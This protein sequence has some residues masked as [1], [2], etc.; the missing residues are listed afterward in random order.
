M[1]SKTEI[2]NMAIA[3]L[4]TGKRL[5][6]IETDQLQEAK[7]CRTFFDTARDATLR[8]FDWPFSTKIKNLG[9]VERFD[10]RDFG[11]NTGGIPL[12]TG[13]ATGANQSEWGYAY[14]Y[15]S[16]CIKARR[17]LSGVR[18]DTR[19][20]REPFK[21]ILENQDRLIYCDVEDAALEYTVLVRDPLFYPADF[22]IALSYRLAMY[23]SPTLTK[24][25][26]FRMKTN[27]HGLYE[28]EISRAQASSLNEEQ[29]E[30]EVLSEFE[31]SR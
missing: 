7:I 6:N 18:N 12:T 24:G 30:E 27:L 31:R 9:L 29:P 22:I 19:Q 15:P 13:L 2:C 21:I 26:P 16:D 28:A 8:D 20:S 5:S 10:G 17:I 3:H 25:D 14:E 23:I 1:P 4:G 11:S